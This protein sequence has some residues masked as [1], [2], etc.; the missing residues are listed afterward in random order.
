M[1]WRKKVSDALAVR[2]YGASIE[3]QFEFLTRRWS[4]SAI[5]PNSGGHDPIIGQRDQH[6]DRARYIDFHTGSATVRLSLDSEWVTPTGGGYFF[7]PPIN[8]L[9]D[10]LGA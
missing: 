1:R 9:V 6:G 4:S 8:A 7:A 5:H 2:S 10:V 3:N